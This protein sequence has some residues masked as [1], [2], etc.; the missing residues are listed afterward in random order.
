MPQTESTGTPDTPNSVES[1]ESCTR[2]MT[3]SSSMDT[4]TE[5]FYD[6]RSPSSMEA[7]NLD[8]ISDMDNTN[9]VSTVPRPN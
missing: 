9:R 6:T 2:D 3:Y 7:R 8:R 1:N 5:E 4:V